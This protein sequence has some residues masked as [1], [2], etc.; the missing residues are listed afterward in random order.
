MLDGIQRRHSPEYNFVGHRESG[1][2]ARWGRSLE[3]DPVRAPWPEL[4][5]ISISNRCAKGCDFCY[6][7]S[8]PD[9]ASM[10][11]ADYDF[12]LDCLTSPRWGTPFQVALGG[13]EPLEHPELVDILDITSR[14]GII[15]NLTTNGMLLNPTIVAALSGRVGAVALSA[16][17]LRLLNLDKVSLLV[18]HGV[19]TNLHFILDEDTLDEAERIASGELDCELGELSAVVFLTR[20]PRGRS[21]ARGLLRFGDP[22]LARF[23]DAVADRRSKLALGFD[24]CAVPLLLQHGRID[25]R[26]VDACECGFFSIYVDEQLEVRPCSFCP[27]GDHA[28]NLRRVDFAKVWEDYLAEYRAGQSS[29]SCSRNCAGRSHCRGG[30]PIFPEISFCYLPESRS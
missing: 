30:C 12:V 21:N 8:T 15:A 3:E 1:F 26:T 10:S 28:W 2:T 16:Y 6:R 4:V 14:H 9:G 19:R 25:A 20:K 27:T 23:L 13:G 29:V 18:R 17:G 11:A 5:D 7:D 22:R 24:A